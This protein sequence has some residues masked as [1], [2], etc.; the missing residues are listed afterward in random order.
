MRMR[1]FPGAITA[2]MSVTVACDEPGYDR[3]TGT[4]LTGRTGPAVPTTVPAP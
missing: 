1:L 4:T 2:V 3:L